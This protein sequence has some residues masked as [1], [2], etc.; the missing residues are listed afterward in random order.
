M[1][2]EETIKLTIENEKET[3]C[4]KEICENGIYSWIVSYHIDTVE[5]DYNF[6]DIGSALLYIG[7]LASHG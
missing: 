7:G 6:E 5:E 1:E 3:I 4:L 2:R